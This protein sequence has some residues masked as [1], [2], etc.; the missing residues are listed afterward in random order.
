MIQRKSAELC[1]LR[2]EKVVHVEPVGAFS[3]MVGR[4]PDN[5]LV[6][7]D[8]RVS[9]HHL[10][11]HW[12]GDKLVLRD[13]GSTNGTFVN[14]DRARD[15]VEL[16]DGDDV[17]LGTQLHVRVR[18]N[19]LDQP[20]QGGT[21]RPLLTDLTTGIAYALRRDRFRI[22]SRDDADLRLP[23]GPA[24]AATLTLHEDGEIWVG[25]DE[26]E[27]LVGIGEPFEVARHRLIVRDDR[28]AVQATYQEAVGKT[29]YPYR[30]EVTLAGPTGPE[31]TLIDPVSDRR[32]TIRAENRVALLYVL[33]RHTV[34]DMENGVQ[35]AA[36]GWCPDEEAMLGV[37]GK[38]WESL[39]GNNYQVLLCRLR[40]ELTEAGLD[41]WFIE[42]RRGHTRVVLEDIKIADD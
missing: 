37:W 4:S 33:A 34:E 23:E 41:G 22:G 17:R 32:H 9:G 40:K 20:V 19:P 16:N 35:D 25:S 14:G 30:L 29:R 6:L 28:S 2:G 15:V 38:R 26:A 21:Y 8:T 42:K 39:G 18:V 10:I 11:V 1:V 31:A 13:L 27:Y 3:L 7:A 24:V 5:D 36:R 12:L